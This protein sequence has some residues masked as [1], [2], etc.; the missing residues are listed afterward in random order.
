MNARSLNRPGTDT[1]SFLFVVAFFAVFLLAA[2]V[3]RAQ[4]RSIGPLPPPPIPK[5]NLMYDAK[6]DLGRHLYF[7]KRL[8]GN[9]SIS[10]AFCHNPGL[11]FSDGRPRGLGLGGELGRNSPTVYN[12]SYN[13][14]QFW[15]GRAG[16]LEE[17]A[18]GPIQN[19]NEMNQN[20]DALVKELSA[21]PGYVEKFQT[22]FGSGVSGQGIA[23]AIAAYE[24]TIISRNAPF[25]RFMGG[26]KKAM[27]A[28]AQRGMKLF[29]GKAR[30]AMCHNGPNFT[31]DGFHNLGVPQAGPLKVDEG[32]FGVT[33]R[34]SDVGAFKTPTLRSVA[35]SGPYMHDGAFKTLEEV[36]DFYDRGGGKNPRL[37]PLVQPLHLSKEEKGDL[38]AFLKALTGEKLKIEIPKQLE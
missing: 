18:L 22:A 33:H 7:D 20:L 13:H 32:R 5:S 23:E 26:D 11:G 10:C 36:I 6:V 27:E 14:L 12:T 28:S 17:Q 19:P 29:T 15:D 25:D 8:S 16:S 30:C 38:L 2:G 37:D 34:V 35:E 3:S 4:D 24:R 31:D 21:V 1:V 9:N